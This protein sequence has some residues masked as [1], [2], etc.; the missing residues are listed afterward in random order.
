MYGQDEIFNKL[1]WYYM[2]MYYNVSVSFSKYAFDLSSIL[3]SEISTNW[4]ISGGWLLLT[5]GMSDNH[6]IVLS[7]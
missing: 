5:E 4:H 2:Y 1:F 3:A 7:H 6:F